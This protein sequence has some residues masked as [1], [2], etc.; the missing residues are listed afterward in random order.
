MATS[1]DD[2]YTEAVCQDIASRQR[3]PRGPRSIADALSQLMAKRGYARV[4]A[5]KDLDQLW[6]QVAGEMLAQQS[7][8]GNQRRGVLEIIVTNSAAL[9]ELTFAKRTLIRDLKRLA[10]EQKIRD[11]RFS[12]GAMH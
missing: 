9:Q 5:K 4:Q 12:V 11:L 1:N 2:R 8:V 10:P 7:R 6:E 3:Y